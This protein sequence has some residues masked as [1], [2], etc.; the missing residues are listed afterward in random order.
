MMGKKMLMQ[1]VKKK[2]NLSQKGYLNPHP[3]AL[4]GS[5][6]VMFFCTNSG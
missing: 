4:N 5:V 3:Q 2:N 6:T 1:S